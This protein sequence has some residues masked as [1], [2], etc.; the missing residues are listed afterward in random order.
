MT[1][2]T[3]QKCFTNSTKKKDQEIKFILF[4]MFKFVLFC[5]ALNYSCRGYFLSKFE[6]FWF[7]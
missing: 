3:F 4:L 7:L 1:M 5:F 2:K 6:S